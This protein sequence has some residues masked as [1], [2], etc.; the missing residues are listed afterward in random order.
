MSAPTAPTIAFFSMDTA[1]H[2]G[3]LRT[4]IRAVTARGIAAVVFTSATFAA[5]VERAGG[6]FVDLF[7]GRP[8]ESADDESTPRSCRFVTFAGCYAG[9]V[10]RE[11]DALRPSLVVYDAF[12]VVGRVAAR[13]LGIPYVDL[14]AGHNVDPARFVPLLE[15]DPHVLVSRRCHR[16]V[17]TLRTRYGIDDASPFS[18]VSA[19]S[20]FLNLYGEP[21][22]YLSDVERRVFE[23]V[24]FWGS[25]PPLDEI[26]ARSAA[27]PPPCFA[28]GDPTALKVYV[29]FGTVV[30]RYYTPEAVAALHAI[31]ECMAAMPKVRALISLGGAEIDADTRRAVSRPNVA[32]ESYVDQWAVLRHADVFITHNGL[33]STHEAIFNRVPMISYPFFWDQPTM[34]EKCRLLGLAIPLTDSPCAAI[35]ETR[36]RSALADLSSRREEMHAA[37]TGAREW[38]CEAIEKRDAVVDRLLDLV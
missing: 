1:Q 36:L 20:P 12:A 23:P 8:L 13:I 17:A 9:D 34:A 16:A 11:L 2:F 31:A 37:L 15:T 26:A 18:Y 32:V 24:A 3:R 38:E 27:E 25:L 14:C 10:A 22:Q 28:A 35:D 5:D 29:S 6:R 21:P 7:A 33:N 19:L 4:L 30:W